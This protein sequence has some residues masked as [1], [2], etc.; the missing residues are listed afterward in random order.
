MRRQNNRHDSVFTKEVL[1]KFLGIHILTGYHKLPSETTWWSLDE[2]LGVP[3]VSEYMPRNGFL[4]IKRNLHFADN[5]MAITSNDRKC[6]I[7][8]LHDV[9]QKNVCQFGMLHEN[10]SIDESMVQYFGYHSAK[11]FIMGKL[12][13]YDYRNWAL[14]SSD[15]YCYTF[16][17]CCR[18]ISSC[19]KKF[20]IKSA[21]KNRRTCSL[22]C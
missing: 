10:L 11:Q 12:I 21:N 8:S 13:R 17:I 20:A 7:R 2:D 16:D 14:T 6:K 18:K 19:C 4:E 9:L 1:R 5:T 22:L 15:G 3:L